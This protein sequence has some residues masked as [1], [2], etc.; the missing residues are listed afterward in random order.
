MNTGRT[1][2]KEVP[3]GH[4]ISHFIGMV[5]LNI[6]TRPLFLKLKFHTNCILTDQN[7][8][9]IGTVT[10]IQSNGEKLCRRG[11]GGD[12]NWRPC[13]LLWRTAILTAVV[14][15]IQRPGKATIILSSDLFGPV[16]IMRSGPTLAKISTQTTPTPLLTARRYALLFH[17]NVVIRF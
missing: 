16:A 11:G 8:F 6:G 3:F 2:I 9:R 1:L 14:R 12:S 17:R 10:A 13:I 5:F 15:L 4:S 7:L